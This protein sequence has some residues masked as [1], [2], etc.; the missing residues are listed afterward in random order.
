MLSLESGDRYLASL[1]AAARGD[2]DEFLLV[3]EGSL[4]DERLA[5]EGSFSGLA[6]RRTADTRRRMVSGSRPGPDAP[7]ELGQLFAPGARTT[8]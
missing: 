4:Y 5:G 3:V 8:G 2:D 7:S 6:S 1:E